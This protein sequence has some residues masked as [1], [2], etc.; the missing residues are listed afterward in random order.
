MLLVLTRGFGSSIPIFVVFIPIWTSWLWFDL[1]MIFYF[2]LSLK[3]IID[4]ITQSSI[5]LALVAPNRGRGTLVLV[6]RAWLCMLGKDSASFRQS[7][8]ECSCHES[9]VFRIFS[10]INNS[11]VYSFYRNPGHDCSLYDCLLDS[12]GRL[13]YSQ[14]MTKHSLSLLVMRMLITLSGWS[15][16]L[17]L[18]GTG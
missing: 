9:C 16:S 7:R 6:L 8:L 18:I 15:L 11:Y 10:R 3:Y 14:L 4:T 17:L 12:M 1:I 5:S 13:G 2:V